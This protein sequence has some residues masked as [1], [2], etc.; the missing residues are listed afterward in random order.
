MRYFVLYVFHKFSA[1]IYLFGH[2]IQTLVLNTHELVYSMRDHKNLSVPT[3]RGFRVSVRRS[4][5]S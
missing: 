4:R 3:G 5:L 1:S 2:D